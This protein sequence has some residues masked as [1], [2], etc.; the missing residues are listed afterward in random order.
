MTEEMRKDIAAVGKAIAAL[1]KT[2]DAVYGD[3]E[4]DS[5]VDDPAMAALPTPATE[6]PPIPTIK[7]AVVKRLFKDGDWFDDFYGNR[8]RFV[9][10]PE[11][12]LDCSIILRNVDQ[13][14]RNLIKVSAGYFC[15]FVSVARMVNGKRV[16][17]AKETNPVTYT[18]DDFITKGLVKKD[19][20]FWYG[21]DTAR[22]VLFCE[23]GIVYFPSENRQGVFKVTEEHGTG[24]FWIYQKE[25]DEALSITR[26]GQVVAAK[27]FWEDR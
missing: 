23:D 18:V 15:Q 3:K 10:Y 27:H 21:G 25:A 11:R 9:A 7:E 5:K 14:G 26:N 20:V 17:I 4:P 6:A 8:F 12:T 24:C 13:S 2:I 22:Q 16:V 19:D 1:A